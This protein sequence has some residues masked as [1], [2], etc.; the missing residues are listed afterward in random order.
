M[1]TRT[2]P[3]GAAWAA[4]RR[5]IVSL[6]VGIVI[7]LAGAGSSGASVVPGPGLKT[8]FWTDVADRAQNNILL[9]DA[10][11]TYWYTSFYL[12]AGGK[13]VLRGQFPHAR[14][15]FLF[16]YHL[17]TPADGLNDDQIVPDPG[18]E[19]PFLPGADRTVTPRSYTVTVTGSAP[20][21][22]G[23]PRTP[24]TIYAGQRS[25]QL[26]YRVYVP[27]QGRD[28][29][30]GAGVPDATYVSAS[31]AS[32]GGQAAC[33]GLGNNGATIPN[34]LPLAAP[35]FLAQ[36]AEDPFSDTHPATNPVR[37]YAVFNN[38]RLLE[39][40]YA[41]T[42]R[43][44]LIG[45][46]PSYRSGL[47]VNFNADSS[48]L[49]SYVD[50]DLGPA[51][52][53][54]NILVLRGKLPTTPQTYGGEPTMQA[55]TQ[56]RYWSLCMNDSWASGKV[57]DCLYDEQVPLDSQR[58]Y[59]IVVSL[60]GDRPADATAACGVGW[61]DWGNLGDGFFRPT[62]GLL[63]IRNQL[64]NPSFAQAVANV[65]VPDTESQT[66]GAY[67]PS[68]SYETAAQFVARGCPAAK[69]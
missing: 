66:V 19:N 44:S 39:P 12:P 47:A 26:V 3:V 37:W 42:W 20:P 7:G 4:S 59:T 9:P 35:L 69:P 64:P 6:T 58:N 48:F 61:L 15:F 49:Y 1:W 62:A 2:A 27:D 41:G 45:L 10:N 53:G 34:L 32:V 38:L 36:L 56:L 43:Q 52:A 30:G 63:L 8:C 13:V 25:I 68:G 24:N 54:R 28:Q 60:P 57:G 21:A 40:F 11:A 55:A 22:A 23:Q 29:M 33:S 67:M 50:R 65:T 51:S 46:L 31:G 17:A 5:A 18:S 16:N 14:S